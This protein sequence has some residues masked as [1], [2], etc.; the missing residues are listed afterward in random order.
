MSTPSA[1]FN[2]KDA[3]A[4]T[5]DQDDDDAQRKAKAA[6]LTDPDRVIGRVRTF[7]IQKGKYGAYKNLHLRECEVLEDTDGNILCGEY[8]LPR[9]NGVLTFFPN[10]LGTAQTLG[11]A[12]SSKKSFAEPLCQELME[13]LDF[14]HYNIQ[15]GKEPRLHVLVSCEDK[16]AVKPK[17]KTKEEEDATEDKASTTTGYKYHGVQMTAS[18]YISQVPELKEASRRAK[19]CFYD[20]SITWNQGCDVI[21][22]RN[23]ND[24]I[25]Y[26]ADDTQGESVIFCVVVETQTQAGEEVRALH[27]KP[28]LTK[29]SKRDKG[30]LKRT[31]V[32]LEIWADEGD[33][34]SMD[35]TYEIVRA[36]SLCLP[37]GRALKVQ[38]GD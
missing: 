30:K 18:H 6:R 36:S 32:E 20:K 3:A 28:D 26:H 22:Y 31:D 13:T 24:K 21:L 14:R 16:K 17:K 2:K 12:Q 27:V 4:V 23:G 1:A 7:D 10:F 34:Y 37:R 25:G 29:G 11:D 33:A 19:Q 5:K 15:A 9:G 8:V 35:G 38:Q